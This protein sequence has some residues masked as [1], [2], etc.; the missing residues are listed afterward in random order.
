MEF[1]LALNYM[2]LTVKRKLSK[3]LDLWKMHTICFK[4]KTKSNNKKKLK[5]RVRRK[6]N[7]E[8][9]CLTEPSPVSSRIISKNRQNILNS[10]VYSS[11]WPLCSDKSNRKPTPIKPCPHSKSISHYNIRQIVG[12]KENEEVAVV[13][14]NFCYA[15]AK[16]N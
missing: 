15:S 2:S 4:L 5:L 10:S 1:K 3:V 12:M 11:V 16:F 6:S 7:C 13:S 9:I 8:T 14:S